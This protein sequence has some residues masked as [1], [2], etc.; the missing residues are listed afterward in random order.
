MNIGVF[1]Q[2]VTVD[3]FIDDVRAASERGIRSVWLSQI[4]GID[5]IAACAIAG[6][7]VPDVRL[8]TGVVPTYMR[9][10]MVMAS[11]ARTT[12]QVTHGRFTLGIG[13]SH[14]IVIES[15]LGMDFSKPVLHL[16]EYLDIL[17]PLLNGEPADAAGSTLTFHGT[18]DVPSEPV[19]LVV[20]ALGP[21]LLALA[22]RRTHGTVTW[23]TGPETIRT[24]VAPVIGAAAAEA[25]RP[26]P[27]IVMALPTVVTDDEAAARS[28]VGSQLE[29]YGYLPS[30]RAMLDREG[31]AGPADVAIVGTEDQVR[32]GIE[33]SFEAG[34]TEYVAAVSP[35]DHRTLDFLATLV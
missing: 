19:P 24:H 16:R 27:R 26:A 10:P 25:G 23:M 12:Q 30:Y 15:M 17:V 8:G 1:F 28:L 3:E 35:S 14:Q 6:R 2:P 33:K 32:A 31:A 5:A 22:G 21:Q 34:V 13:L 18:V 7:E 29:M 9:H 4:F 20:A 11:Q